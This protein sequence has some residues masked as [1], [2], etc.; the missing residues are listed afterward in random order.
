MGRKRPATP[1]ATKLH[2]EMMTSQRLNLLF[3][4][5]LKAREAVA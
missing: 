1:S 3:T 5:T 4:V 2:P